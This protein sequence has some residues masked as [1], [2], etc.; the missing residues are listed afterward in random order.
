MSKQSTFKFNQG[1]F[2]T[3]ILLLQQTVEE[4]LKDTLTDMATYTV[5]ISPVATGAYVASHSIQSNT[6]SRGRRKSS[7][8]KAPDTHSREEGLGNLLGDIEALDLEGMTQVTLRN[9]ADHA[10]D[11]EEKHGYWVYAQVKDRFS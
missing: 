1:K 4:K 2:D 9:D 7:K 10:Q 11:V 5:S 3:D 6:S 8:N